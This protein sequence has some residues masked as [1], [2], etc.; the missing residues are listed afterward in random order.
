MSAPTI[1]QLRAAVKAKIDAMGLG[2]T[3]VEAWLGA[4]RIEEIEQTLVE[5]VVTG[6][7]HEPDTK[8]AAVLNRLVSVIVRKRLAEAGSVAEADAV[9]QLAE[10]IGRNLL[11]GDLSVA[12]DPMALESE[13]VL[14]PGALSEYGVAEAIATVTYVSYG[15]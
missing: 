14:E 6:L 15:G 9:V 11:N 12:A 2:V 5:I 7:R 4:R 13:P 10:T 1:A 3:A 8:D